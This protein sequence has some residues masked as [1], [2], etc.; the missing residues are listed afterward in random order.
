MA[1]N[2][3]NLFH[4][5]DVY[6][7]FT[8]NLIPTEIFCY[9]FDLCKTNRKSFW[10]FNGGNNDYNRSYS[11]VVKSNWWLPNNLCTNVVWIGVYFHVRWTLHNWWT[12]VCKKKVHVVRRKQM[13]LNMKK[14]SARI[15]T[16][17]GLSKVCP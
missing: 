17:A 14:E 8:F 16:V 4:T 3:F 9:I 1:A 12:C 2:M 6:S 7:E 15:F 13:N 11:R 10:W 5:F